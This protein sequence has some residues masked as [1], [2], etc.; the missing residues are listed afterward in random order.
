MYLRS[1][2]KKIQQRLNTKM[3]KIDVDIDFEFTSKYDK[4][5]MKIDCLRSKLDTDCIV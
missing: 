5:T 1:I 3:L 4:L 2:I